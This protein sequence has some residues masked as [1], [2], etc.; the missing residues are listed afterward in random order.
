MSRASVPTHTKLALMNISKRQVLCFRDSVPTKATSR[1]AVFISCA[2][3]PPV[4]PLLASASVSAACSSREASLLPN[5]FGILCFFERSTLIVLTLFI[6][7]Q[8]YILLWFCS[9]VNVD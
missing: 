3:H 2:T 4:R 7:M 1:E 6:V 8:S 5:P 9:K